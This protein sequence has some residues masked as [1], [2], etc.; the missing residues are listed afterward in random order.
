MVTH[1]RTVVVLPRAHAWN[2]PIKANASPCVTTALGS[3]KNQSLTNALRKVRHRVRAPAQARSGAAERMQIG[4]RAG[5]QG[6][7]AVGGL[8]RGAIASNNR[9]WL[10]F[11]RAVLFV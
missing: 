8:S 2:S 9:W 4:L 1:F 5:L 11:V 7:G 10:D 6:A 3:T